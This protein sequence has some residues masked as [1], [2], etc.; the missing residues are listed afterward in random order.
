MF[1]EAEDD[2]SGCHAAELDLK[3]GRIAHAAILAAGGLTC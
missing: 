2:G 1:A 3:V